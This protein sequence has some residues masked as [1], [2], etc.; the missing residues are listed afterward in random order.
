MI[1]G[2]EIVVDALARQFLS[3]GHQTVVLA[4]NPRSAY[5]KA[6]YLLPYRVVRHPRFISTRRLIDPYAY[7]LK[8]VHRTHGFDILHCHST[9]PTGYLGTRVARSLGV[10]VVITSHGG[11]VTPTNSKLSQERVLRRHVEALSAADALVAI[12]DFTAEGYRRLAPASRRV[13]RIPNGVDTAEFSRA[14]PRPSDLDPDIQP[15]RYVLFLGRLSHRKGVDLLI[16]A[17]GKIPTEERPLLVIAGDGEKRSPLERRVVELGLASAI[18]FVGMAERNRK[19]FLLQNSLFGVV[20]S[21]GWE[22]LPLAV[23]ESFAAGRPLV[24]TRI[25]GIAGVVRHQETGWLVEPESPDALAAAIRVAIADAPLRERLGRQA[26]VEASRF[27]WKIV[28]RSYLDLFASLIAER[29]AAQ[30]R[31][32]GDTN[33]FSAAR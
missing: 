21:R 12:S 4:P 3:A 30:E 32:T 31:S 13:V 5:R 27:D 26:Q 25:P 8:R 18:R 22:G 24:A 2:Q 16:E 33:A 10:P 29:Q 7:W 11:D 14:A 6:D 1:G 17:F 15:G 23:L 20:P 9:Y 28:A 19:T